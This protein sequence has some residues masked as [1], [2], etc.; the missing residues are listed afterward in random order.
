VTASSKRDR[1]YVTTRTET[2][3]SV[4]DLDESSDRPVSC[5]D[6]DRV[7]DA[8]HTRYSDPLASQ[9][10]LS[11]P[12][13]AV[14]M[15]SG[16]ASDLV[17]EG[18]LSGEIVLVAHRG[19]QVSAF[20]DP[21]K[22]SQLLLQDVLDLGGPTRP[23]REPT[24]IVFDP[25]THLAYAS[26]YARDLPDLSDKKILARVGI[27]SSGSDDYPSSLFDAGVVSLEGVSLGRDTRGIAL[28][29]IVPGRALVA[30]RV[31]NGSVLWVDLQTAQNG[32]GEPTQA[33]VE[34][35]AT[36]G[37]GPTRVI[38]G[39][40]GDR[41]VVIVSCFDARQI[42]ILDAATAETLSVIHNFSG[43]FEVALD[44]ARQRLY[45]ADFRSSVVRI[46]DLA[47]LLDGASETVPTARIIATLGHPQL[48]QE[49]Q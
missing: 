22:G 40:L 15:A 49:L 43:P 24:G 31:P 17:P 35:Y 11:L 38:T 3:V 29:P 18:D 42:F 4:V 33:L 37:R 2:N 12:R 6:T 46:L 48:V 16:D 26:V 41:T 10:R 9:R 19:G 5:N 8:S 39:T 14:A 21:G 27:E 23:V 25:V 28:D 47:P 34:Q 36:V 45:V 7:C 1:I 30:S 20:L 44:S 32:E 13:E